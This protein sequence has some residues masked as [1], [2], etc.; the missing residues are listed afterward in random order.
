M[1]NVTLGFDEPNDGLLM[2]MELAKFIDNNY[3]GKVMNSFFG[4]F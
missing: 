3:I 4:C 2:Y 1:N